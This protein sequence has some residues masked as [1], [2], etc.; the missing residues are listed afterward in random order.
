MD[1]ALGLPTEHAAVLALRTQQVIAHESSVCDTVDPL[2][3]SYY[4]ESL[5]DEIENRARAY[6]ERIDELGGAVRAIEM[7]FQQREI[8]DAAYRW[9][10]SVEAG[11]SVVVG[12]N[13]FG[14][15]EETRPPV[16]RVDETLQ[17]QR[18]ARLEALRARR[19][20]TAVS[21]ALAAVE[22][23]ARSNGNLMPPIVAAAESY[24]TLGEIADALRR[25]FGEFQES[26][27]F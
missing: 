19:D 22:R 2:A 3:G 9:Q 5:T 12:V 10:K 18:K 11:T 1:E 27:S 4:I 17:Q 23:T 25:V 7:G 6:I 16:L 13:R 8:H 14:E 20:A 21:E 24:A 15:G 26:F